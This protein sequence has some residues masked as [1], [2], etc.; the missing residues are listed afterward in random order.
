MK[1]LGVEAASGSFITVTVSGGRMSAA[2]KVIPP[3]GGSRT[4]LGRL[5]G[6]SPL[7]SAPVHLVISEADHVH[8]TLQLPPMTEKERAEVVQREGS[9]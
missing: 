5:L 8:R 3:P 7:S 2:R 6:Q 4:K 1:R 9:R